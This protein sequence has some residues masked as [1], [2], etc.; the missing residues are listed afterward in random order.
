MKTKLVILLLMF[1]SISYAQMEKNFIDQP[2]IEVTG[3][4]ELDVIPN[5]I[6][7]QIIINET[8]NKGKKSVET[9]EKEMMKKLK[10]IGI[11]ITKDLSIKDF[12]SNFKS[13]FLKKTDILTSKKYQLLVHDGKT[14][15]M[16]FFELESIGLSNIS[17]ERVDNS[18]L[19]R[20]RNKVKVNAIKAAKEKASMLAH[21]IGQMASSAIFIQEQNPGYYRRPQMATNIMVKSMA[22]DAS[23]EVMPE[24]EFE[25]IHLEYSILVRFAL[26]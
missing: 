22:M 15:G 9:L 12:T 17:I 8:D 16:V 21:A 18:E 3:K 24:I 5:E 25:K 1:A 19:T 2:Y 23:P 4:A 14:A 7:M 11:D 20:L 10:E 13:Y 26:Q 6:Y